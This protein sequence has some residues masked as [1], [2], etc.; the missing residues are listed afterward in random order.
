MPQLAKL[1]NITLHQE[2][3]LL[4]CANSIRSGEQMSQAASRIEGRPVNYV[5]RTLYYCYPILVEKGLLEEIPV[6]DDGT[7]K[8]TK[9]YKTTPKGL[10]V[11]RHLN[12]IRKQYLEL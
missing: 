9:E 12:S 5:G 4:M 6:P 2:K 3:V 7:R 11:I 10:D 1:P 8:V